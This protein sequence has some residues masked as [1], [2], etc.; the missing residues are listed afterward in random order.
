MAVWR[1][2]TISDVDEDETSTLGSQRLVAAATRPLAQ[3]P[4]GGGVDDGPKVNRRWQLGGYRSRVVLTDVLIV[5]AS[6]LLVSVARFG[7]EDPARLA[8]STTVL[9]V[10]YQFVAVVTAFIWICW[11]LMHGCWSADV[12]GDGLTEVKRIV[13][14]FRHLYLPWW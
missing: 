8:S 1:A 12:P 6:T 9:A 3:T 5:L 7:I 10:S 11:L 13:R 14:A 4:Q 2:A